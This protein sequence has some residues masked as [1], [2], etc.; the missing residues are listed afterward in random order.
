MSNPILNDNNL[1]RN[2]Q[3]VNTTAYAY[4]QS[5]TVNG[6]ISVTAFLS[7]ILVLSAA[8]CWSRFSLGYTDSGVMLTGIGVITGFILALVISF[9]S[10]TLG[11]K[12]LKY[13]D[14]TF[15]YQNKR[16]IFL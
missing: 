1:E 13:L 8:F 14:Q 6:T 16:S 4:G 5:M 3:Y 10:F 15:L 9:G 11:I 2:S 12:K 7:L